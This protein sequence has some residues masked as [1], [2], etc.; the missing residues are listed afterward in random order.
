[1]TVVCRLLGSIPK[2]NSSP[3]IT[4]VT[5]N[6]SQFN[7]NPGLPH[8]TALQRVLHCLK[9]T[10]D[11]V[12]T[13]VVYHFNGWWIYITSYCLNSAH[14]LCQVTWHSGLLAQLKEHIIVGICCFWHSWREPAPLLVSYTDSNYAG[15]TDTQQSSSGYVF[16][17]GQGAISWSSKQQAIVTTLSCEAEYIASCHATKEAI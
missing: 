11:Q 6:L 15:C 12:L 8:W 13:L 9:Q 1:M 10:R 3:D 14:R 16:T 2:A 7:S 4:F 17:L 5:N